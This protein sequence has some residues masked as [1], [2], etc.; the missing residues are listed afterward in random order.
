MKKIMSILTILV[1]GILVLSGF[2]VAAITSNKATTVTNN[3]ATMDNHPPDAPKVTGPYF[4]KVGIPYE[5]TIRAIDPDGD[6]V[7][8][9]IDWADGDISEWTVWYPSGEEITQSHYYSEQGH[10]SIKARA[11]DIHGAIGDWGYI[12]FGVSKTSQQST[13]GSS[14]QNVMN[15]APS[16][17]TIINDGSLSGYVNDTSGNP[18]EGALVR[19]YFH[20]TYEEDYSDCT[21]YYHVTNIPICY[22]LKNATCSKEGYKTEWVLL[23]IVEDTTHDFILTSI[24]NPPDAPEIEGPTVVKPGTYDWTFKA[25]D[26]DGD[27][28]SYEIDW[29]DGTS[30]KWIGPYPSGEPVT[31]SHT[32]HAVG[33]VTISARAK[34]IYG[35]IG[36]E[37]TFTFYVGKSKSIVN[38]LLL[39]FLDGF[40]FLVRLLNLI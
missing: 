4:T 16:S 32:Y 13:T 10:F 38:S 7:S 22:C 12:T 14:S 24:N 25:I 11:K 6:N 23:G 8:Y 27:D 3:L 5:C 17:R 21:G 1:V 26:P 39:W 18:I 30:D 15:V 28:V 34:D 40:P 2:G 20:E 31:V 36:N 19:V 37:S 35:A 33:Y 9:Q 29:G